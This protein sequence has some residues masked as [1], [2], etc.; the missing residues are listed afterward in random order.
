[1]CL[2]YNVDPP[3]TAEEMALYVPAASGESDLPIQPV[4]RKYRTGRGGATS[5]RS[6]PANRSTPTPTR[7]WM[8]ISPLPRDEY[9]ADVRLQ[10]LVQRMLAA[11]MIGV[12]AIF[13]P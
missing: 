6:N 5:A 10:D 13:M 4:D 1:S 8:Q 2:S 3:L 11:K 12:Q 7:R 9:S